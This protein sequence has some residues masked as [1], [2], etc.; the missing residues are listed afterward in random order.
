MRPFLIGWA[1]YVLIVALFGVLLLRAASPS[2]DFRTFYAAGYLVRTHPSQLFD[3]ASQHQVQ[4]ALISPG[5]IALPFLH[6]SYEALVFAP[7]SLLK[8]QTAYFCFMGLNLLLVLGIFAA[9]YPPFSQEIPIWQPRPGLMLFPYLPLLLTIWHGQDSLL[10]LLVC[11]LV[12]RELECE[13]DWTAGALLALG[14]F[15]FQLAIPM[16]VLLTARRGWRFGT[17]FIAGAAAV[18]ALCIAITGAHAQAV[19]LRLLTA[20]SLALNNG[21]S[22]Q[23][24]MVIKPLA[25][26]NLF[27]LLFPVTRFLPSRLAFAVVAAASLALMCWCVYMVRKTR[28][29]RV[30]LAVCVVCAS[31]VSYHMYLYDLDV[32]LLVPA[33]LAP[34]NDRWVLLLFYGLTLALLLFTGPAW[35]FLLAIPTLALLWHVSRVALAELVPVAA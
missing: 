22:A 34:R 25:M 10:F 3:L 9:A 33:L 21:V 28:D 31:L 35:L 5:E 15:K 6:P 11:A 19:M 16:A 27:G 32:L 18:V 14:L 8:Y 7:F 17:A 23:Q 4:S 20:G 12:W 1:V 26:P 30:S 13:P 2:F 29:E 24:T